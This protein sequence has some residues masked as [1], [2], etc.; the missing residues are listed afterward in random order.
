M[1]TRLKLFIN[2]TI[3]LDK[4][5]LFL[6]WANDLW[7]EIT[8]QILK[9]IKSLCDYYW[10]NNI[11]RSLYPIMEHYHYHSHISSLSNE[12]ILHFSDIFNWWS[13]YNGISKAWYFYSHISSLF[14]CFFFIPCICSFHKLE[15]K[16]SI[17]IF[18]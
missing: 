10:L 8:F 3:L 13:K 5:T 16:I 17:T 2:Q 4:Q 6:W 18:S 14:S 11:W 7:N 9:E 1:Q 15:K 12:L